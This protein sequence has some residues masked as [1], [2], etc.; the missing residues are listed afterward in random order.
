[1]EEAVSRRSRAIGDGRL[2]ISFEFFPPRGDEAAARLDETVKRLAPLRPDFASVTY[3]AG[4]STRDATVETLRKV[5]GRADVP[6]A[7]HLTC[8]GADRKA[9]GT[10]LD[11]YETSGVRHVVALR[12]DPPA[13]IGTRYTP[14]P[15]GYASSSDLVAA[16]KRRAGFEVSVSAYPERHPDSAGW[17]EEIDMLRRKVDAGADRAITQFFF[18]NDHFESYVERVRAA[19]IGIP[20]VPG[21][22]PIDNFE[23][24]LVFASKCGATIPHWL[25]RR[26]AGLQNDAA[27]RA[28]V[29]SAVLGE[30]VLDLV[31]RGVDRFH[32]YTMNRAELVLAACH[33]LGRGPKPESLEAAWNVTVFFASCRLRGGGRQA[34]PRDGRGHGHHGPGPETPG[35]GLSRQPVRRLAVGPARQQ[36]SSEPDPARC[37]S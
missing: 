1:M 6:V 20:I 5:S 2:R 34:H 29:A 16:V 19:G 13:G 33:L 11:A 24:V 22:L 27:T 9:I 12:G 7:G 37:G 36:R 4:G 23:Q 17:R 25:A 10:V 31:D 3:G 18:D 15:G 30:Q 35:R 32:F 28:L 26:F 8:V 21:I 14:H